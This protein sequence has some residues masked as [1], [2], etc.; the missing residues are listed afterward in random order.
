MFRLKDKNISIPQSL[1]NYIDTIVSNYQKEK[2]IKN[3]N[4]KLSKHAEYNIVYGIP[5]K[6]YTRYSLPLPIR[7]MLETM[8]GKVAIVEAIQGIVPKLKNG[9]KIL[10]TNIPEEF[11]PAKRKRIPNELKQSSTATKKGKEY[12]PGKTTAR[13]NARQ[14]AYH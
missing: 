13:K 6:H 5:N 3:F 2:F 7:D 12:D 14:T 1:E 9:E 8:N 10:N 11:L 4:R